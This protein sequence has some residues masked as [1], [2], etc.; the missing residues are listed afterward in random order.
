MHRAPA[1]FFLFALCS[2]SVFAGDAVDQALADL[3][4]DDTRG[5]LQSRVAGSL[6]TR[7]DSGIAKET[8]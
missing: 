3:G 1:F 8:K 7:A 2:T 4:A 5:L 6:V